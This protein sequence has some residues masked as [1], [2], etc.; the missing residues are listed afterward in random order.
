MSEGNSRALRTA[1]RQAR[2]LANL[3]GCKLNQAQMTLAIDVYGYMSWAKLKSAIE[4][5]ELPERKACLLDREHQNAALL[6][7]VIK[8]SWQE[9]CVNLSKIK[10]LKG[11]ETIEIISSILNIDK[12]EL[13]N[14]I[15]VD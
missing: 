4:K 7:S 6:I 9:W 8:T 1:Q 3:S 12:L 15:R 10:Y 13:H 5:N 2:A 14:L 11:I